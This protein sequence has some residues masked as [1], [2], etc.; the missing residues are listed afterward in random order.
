MRCFQ[1][2]D[3]RRRA[4]WYQVFPNVCAGHYRPARYRNTCIHMP[5]REWRSVQLAIERKHIFQRARGKIKRGRSQDVRT[6]IFSIL[7]PISATFTKTILHLHLARE[8]I[9]TLGT[10]LK[11]YKCLPCGTKIWLKV[12]TVWTVT[13]SMQQM[14]KIVQL[15]K[16]IKHRLVQWAEKYTFTVNLLL[17]RYIFKF[18]PNLIKYKSW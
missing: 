14:L 11:T 2:W 6:L 15:N 10:N 1:Q 12:N 3:E 13:W 5:T 16:L 17:Y 8:S 4:E 7:T 9:W 18:V